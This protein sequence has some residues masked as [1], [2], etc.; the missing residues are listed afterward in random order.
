[1]PGLGL[2]DFETTLV[3]EKRL[4]RVAARLCV[5]DGATVEGYEIHMGVTRGPALARPAL[6][7][8]GRPDGALSWDGQVLA[9]YVHGLFDRPEACRA[10]LAWAGLADAVAVDHRR[11]REESIERL[12]DAM[13]GHL[14]VLALFAA[15][16]ASGPAA[17]QT[18]R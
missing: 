17:L 10:L 15:T 18:R 16:L 8:D 4:E 7:V 14:D 1:M 3:A 9:T 12:A 11:L 6:E 5:G 2:L 13:E